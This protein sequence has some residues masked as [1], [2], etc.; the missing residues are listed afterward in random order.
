M[1]SAVPIGTVHLVKRMS[2]ADVALAAALA[3]LSASV[4]VGFE[5]RDQALPAVS[6]VVAAAHVAPVVWRRRVPRS[7]FA[8]SVGAGAV[9]VASG[10]PMVGLGVAALVMTYSLAA[11]TPR[12]LS[13]VGLGAEVAAFAAAMAIGDVRLDRSTI[14]GN[15]LVLAA[16]WALGDSTR[17]RRE[18][19]ADE[20]DR[21]A[22]QAVVDERLR[23]ARE[24]HD[25]VAHSMSVITVQAGTGRMVIED[26]PA[27]AKAA[28]VAIEHVG[29]QALDEMRRLLDVLRES[30]DD[31][32][33]LAPMP[34]LDDLDRLIADAESG[35]TAVTMHV[36]GRRRPVPPGVE[37]AAYRVVQ[38]ALTNVR[39]H[40]PGVAARVRIEFGD[41]D[42]RIVVE[43]RVPV[44]GPVA[45]ED[46]PGH[47]LAGM[48]ERVA[49][50]G[51]EVEARR[52]GDGQFR[53]WARLPYQAA[54]R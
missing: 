27:Q 45:D 6:W 7:A 47:G 54:G 38:E 41:D 28:L 30:P 40:A 25:I 3:A 13:L 2:W 5:Q 10:W 44:D 26:D 18:L 51:G 46:A 1:P 21:R 23:I 42:L 34:G 14:V 20:Q 9:F 15:V 4:L 8:V 39:K 50:Y 52:N 36:E 43:N 37:L 35:G 12:V 17:R 31:A 19:A 24:L 32:P 16:A 48:R 53:V 22:R 49:L 29:R 11:E 33:A